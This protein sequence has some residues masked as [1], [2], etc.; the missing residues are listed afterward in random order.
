MAKQKITK[1]V[2]N[3]KNVWIGKTTKMT[4]VTHRMQPPKMRTMMGKT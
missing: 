4:N 1:S 3:N 2:P